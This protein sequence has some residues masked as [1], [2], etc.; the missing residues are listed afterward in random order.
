M[1]F[2]WNNA[3]ENAV[4]GVLGAVPEV[5]S[6]L[7]ALVYIFWPQSQED[8]WG[9][10][11]DQVEQLIQ[12]DLNAAVYQQVSDDLA[13]LKGALND[14]LVA[15]QSGDTAV[16]SNQ[17]IATKTVFDT[18]LPHFQSSGSELLL[19]PLFSQFAN[20]YLSLLR[21]GVLKG[22]SWNWNTAYQKQISLELTS[23]ID[24]FISYANT[25]YGQGYWQIANNTSTNYTACQPF[26][27]TNNYV[28]QMTLSVMDFVAMWDY[29]DVSVYP[30]PVSIYL[31]REI[32]SDPVGTCTDSGAINLPTK[33]T[34]PIS[35]LTVWAWDRIDAVQVTYP[36]NG[37]PNGLTQT[38]RMGDQGG[39][40][41]QPPHGGVFA[42][43][44]NPIVS[45][46]GLS[47]DI[48]NAFTFGFKDGSSSGQIG[49]NYPGGGAFAFSY[50]GE[51]LSSVHINGVSQFY[52]SADCAVFGFQFEKTT[53]ASASLL[54]TL[55]ISSPQP[56]AIDQLASL[57][58][59][60]VIDHTGIDP[61]WPSKRET[62]WAYLKQGSNVPS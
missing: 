27:S 43:T 6:L 10:I 17:W 41:N 20:L 53:T 38:P 61:D 16:T 48:L 25:T 59:N 55:L 23:S 39:G 47:G 26:R 28:R 42:L 45:A 24:I 40:S 50:P 34:Q 31:D 62:Y 37:G 46:G 44:N 33:P 9:E 4:A 5:G 3:A 49:G 8:V 35:E 36:P 15:L 56:V 1:A 32:Y 22:D 51:I 19:L 11:K 54:N 2:N 29:F 57:L 18:S 12:Q 52:G 13:G 14:Y 21:D 30:N 7:S 60:Q 58:P